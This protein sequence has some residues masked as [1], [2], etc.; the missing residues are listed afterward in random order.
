MLPKF[1][2]SYWYYKKH[3]RDKNLSTLHPEI[4]KAWSDFALTQNETHA[5][6]FFLSRFSWKLPLNFDIFDLFPRRPY[7]ENVESFFTLY[8]DLEKNEFT[9]EFH[10]YL[11]ERNI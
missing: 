11:A 1:T 3:I 5:F 4:K 7:H 2:D 10:L 9:D 6:K 8:Y